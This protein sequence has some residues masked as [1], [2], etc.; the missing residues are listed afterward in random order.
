[1]LYVKNISGNRGFT[2]VELLVVISII[3]F[4][5][6]T[7]IA[8]VNSARVRADNTSRTQTIQQYINALNLF[9][10]EKG[11]VPR[12]S[13]ANM[14]EYIFCLGGDVLAQCS[15]FNNTL[16][17]DSALNQEFETYLSTLSELEYIEDNITSD[18]IHGPIYI[19]AIP[20]P[21]NMAYGGPGWASTRCDQASIA[22]FLWSLKGEN[23]FCL[24]RYLPLSWGG[25]ITLCYP[26]LENFY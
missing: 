26:L 21:S 1:M 24:P 23:Q 7:V 14:G 9:I 2:L 19:C 16:P 15:Y 25:D 20:E 17:R 22:G 3:G 13:P 10:T 12:P 5:S 11:R 8:A 4:L 18:G 6:S